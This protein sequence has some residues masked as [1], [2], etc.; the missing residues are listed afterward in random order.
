MN[1]QGLPRFLTIAM[2]STIAIA[3]AVPATQA[4]DKAPAV[5]VVVTTARAEK[6]GASLSATG[7]VV[8]PG[9]TVELPIAMTQE[10]SRLS[11]EIAIVGASWS[12][13]LKAGELAGTWSQGGMA[14]PLTFIRK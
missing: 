11:I 9:S 14:L 2:A 6:V 3:A 5:P 12:G 1:S 13:E 8:S 10:G 4:Q 7:T